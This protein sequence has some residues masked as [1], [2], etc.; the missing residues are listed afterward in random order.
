MQSFNFKGL[1]RRQF[2]LLFFF[3]LM[4]GFTVACGV[5]SLLVYAFIFELGMNG[6]TTKWLMPMI[7]GITLIA[8][9]AVACITIKIISFYI[10]KTWFIS[11]THF[12]MNIH[13]SG[14]EKNFLLLSELDKVTIFQTKTL[15][16]F[17]Q[18]IQL[19]FNQKTINIQIVLSPILSSSK[20]VD[21]V[22]FLN[23]INFLYEN[24]LKT[25]FTEKEKST[26][27][28]EIASYLASYNLI[29]YKYIFERNK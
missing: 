10:K 22:N 8:A 7:S 18:S 17:N 24:I 13:Q 25:Q 2:S 5:L 6:H 28:S 29:E 12:E 14:K 3:S 23:F 20:Q 16:G 1:D 15:M 11:F 26:L 21:K 9:I 27:T 4:L 19:K